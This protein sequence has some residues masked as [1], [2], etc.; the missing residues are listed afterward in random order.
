MTATWKTCHPQLQPLSYH[1]TCCPRSKLSCLPTRLNQ[2]TLI[3]WYINHAQPSNV[4][5]RIELNRRACEESASEER[6]SRAGAAVITPFIVAETIVIMEGSGKVL[7]LSGTITFNF[8]GASF[9]LGMQC[10]IQTDKCRLWNNRILRQVYFEV[11]LLTWP[12]GHS[13]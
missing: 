6:Q 10:A 7:L 8:G 5:V 2:I 3:P 4:Y 11:L 12:Y 13:Q 1:H 9:Y